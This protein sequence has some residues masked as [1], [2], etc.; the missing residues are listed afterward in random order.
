MPVISACIRGGDSALNNAFAAGISAPAAPLTDWATK[1]SEVT[2]RR[3]ATYA[4]L[5][6]IVAYSP[7]M[8]MPCQ[9]AAQS[10]FT[11]N[12]IGGRASRI[13][14]RASSANGDSGSEVTS[15]NP[16]GVS[17]FGIMPK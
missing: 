2:H 10:G 1:E 5:F 14:L 4:F 12:G 17:L 6:E 7:L 8:A 3:R 9:L 13:N 15:S 16:C 11:F